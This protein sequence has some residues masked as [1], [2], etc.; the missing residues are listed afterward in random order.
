MSP[1]EASAQLRFRGSSTVSRPTFTWSAPSRAAS[2]SQMKSSP[3]AARTLHVEKLH[4]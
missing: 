1:G 2:D 4:K 3:S